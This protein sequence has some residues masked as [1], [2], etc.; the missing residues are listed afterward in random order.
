M[1]EELFLM[2]RIAGA[3]LVVPGIGTLLRINASD[4][5]TISQRPEEGHMEWR[6]IRSRW[7]TRIVPV[8]LISIALVA[9]VMLVSSPG[10]AAE[11]QQGIQW[12]E[13][14]EE[15]LGRAHVEKR[16]IFIDFFNPN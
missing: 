6:A 16:P 8:S 2:S 5:S 7:F 10:S 12:S 14:F 15:A 13:D 9:Q 11:Q 1:K 4:F 3:P